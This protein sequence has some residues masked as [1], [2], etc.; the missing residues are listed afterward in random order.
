[1]AKRSR[2]NP[3]KARIIT[4]AALAVF[5]FLLMW[6][7]GYPDAVE[8][9]YS[10]GFYYLVCHIFHPIFNLF[11]FSVGDL[12]YI[13]VVI[14]LVYLFVRFIRL[15]IKKQWRTAG[16]LVLGVTIGIQIAIVAFYLLWGLNYYRPTAGER[17]NLQDSTYTA[18]D[19]K[20]VTSLLIDSANA[21]RSR[22]TQADLAERNKTIYATAIGAVK[23]LPDSSNNFA[24]YHPDIKPSLLTPLLNYIG[25][26][27]YYNP[28][29]S[30]SQMNY[31]MPVFLRP[32]VACHELSHQMGYG[33]EDEANFVGFIAGINS[34][35]RLLRYSSYYIGVQEFMYALKQKDSLARKE[36][37]KRISPTVLSDFKQEREYWLAYQ[38]KV[39]KISSL[40]YD[41]FLKANNQP[42]GLNTYNRMVLLVL[43]Y[44]KKHHL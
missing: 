29:T 33:P 15:L 23:Q 18:E 14:Y 32:F 12:I 27:G 34:H 1:M 5:I 36:L 20:T 8:H 40:F 9:Y 21:C 25:T 3:F 24:T 13:A 42:E 43:A 38:G 17:L 44:R 2:K 30:E 37:K 4:I 7:A 16:L 31:Q 26:S 11:P 22:V 28:F 6:F 19:L 41:T 39:E 10:R 35:D